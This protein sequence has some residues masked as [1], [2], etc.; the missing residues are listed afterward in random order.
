MEERDGILNSFKITEYNPEPKHLAI[1]EWREDERPRERLLKS[2]AHTLSDAELLAIVF[3]IGT[4]GISAVDVAR[5]LLKEFKDLSGICSRDVSELSKIRGIGP[6]KAITLAAVFEIARRIESEPFSLK[7]I[8][9]SPEEIANYYIP[10][11]RGARTEKFW[12]LLL[13]SANQV[14]REVL[15]S[16]GSLNASI[17]HPREVFRIAI[18]ESAASIVLLHNHPSGNTEPSR[19][20][21]A[22]TKQLVSA[23]E[24]IDIKVLDHIIIAGETYTSLAEKRLM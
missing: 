23:G 15:V 2:G 8:F 12:I 3:G 19:E 21:I 22:I 1:H 11:F 18:T 10:R 4:R 24:L 9:R 17:V 13:N 6:V 14:F 5:E 7:K 20:D 16:E